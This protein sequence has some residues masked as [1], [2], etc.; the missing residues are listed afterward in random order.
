M[1]FQEDR[2][3]DQQA[4]TQ[5]FSIK[6]FEAPF[7]STTGVGLVPNLFG[8]QRFDPIVNNLYNTMINMDVSLDTSLSYSPQ[9]VQ[10]LQTYEAVYGYE[11]P[12][13]PS[14]MEP[15]V[16]INTFVCSPSGAPSS[17]YSNTD[18]ESSFQGSVRAYSNSPSEIPAMQYEQHAHL[19]FSN[20]GTQAVTGSPI[21][22]V[23][24]TQPNSTLASKRPRS[25][26]S[27]KGTPQKDGQIKKTSR[28]KRKP[29]EPIL[30]PK[31]MSQHAR[32][33]DELN[34]KKMPWAM[35]QNTVNIKKNIP[36][37]QMQ[38][39]RERDK[40]HTWTKEQVSLIAEA[41]RYRI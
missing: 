1:E 27:R 26:R 18:S 37:L 20:P 34:K 4:N 21:S 11:N 29:K 41:Y 5:S 35:I 15:M 30:D 17:P 7:P 3:Y 12:Y 36:A 8:P 28:R 22:D 23:G 24:T 10:P 40:A 9:V 6:Q 31:P 19:S 32:E 33:L 14:F 16:H 2:S 38:C 25:Q 13:E 39:G